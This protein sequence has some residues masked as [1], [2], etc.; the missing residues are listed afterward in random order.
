MNESRASEGK[1]TELDEFRILRRLGGAPDGATYLAHDR[2]LDRPVVLRFFPRPTEGAGDRLEAT[3]ALARVSH[4]SISAVHRVSSLGDRPYA[5]LEHANGDR[6]DTLPAP[7]SPDRVLD[8]GRALAGGIAALH[9]E[10]IAHGDVRPEQIFI[11][12][13]GTPQLVVGHARVADSPAALSRDVRALV[14]LLELYADAEL[15]GRMACVM[16]AREQTAEGLLHALDG[17]TRQSSSAEAAADN[18]Y[19]G[20]DAFGAEHAETFFGREAHVAQAI[21][22]L[23]GA[24]WLLVA[25]P[26]GGGKTSFVQ[27]GLAP[28]VARGDLGERPRWDVVSVVPGR[29]PLHAL[30]AALAPVVGET[31]EALHE[32]LSADAAVA[33]RL[34][35]ARTSTGLLLV[36]DP[37]EDV[38]D[39]PETLEKERTL[40]ALESFGALA[41]GVRL[42]LTLRAD[43]L[44]RLAGEPVGRGWLAASFMLPTMRDAELAKVVTGPARARGF[45]M[46]SPAMVDALVAEASGSP[47]SLPLLSFVLAE[48]WNKREPEAR[49]IPMAALRQLGGAAHSLARRGEVVLASLA[50]A[51]RKAARRVLVA[52]ALEAEGRSPPTRETLG[53]TDGA[54]RRALEALMGGRLVVEGETR[55]LAHGG[56]VDAWPR[57]RAW[58]DEA[59]SAR[60][61]KLRLEAAAREWVRLGGQSDGLWSARQIADLEDPGAIQGSTESAR[62]FL[63]A[64]RRVA[65]R[66][67]R[68]KWAL[69]LGL[70][71]LLAVVAGVAWVGSVRRHRAAA[72]ARVAEARELAEKASQSERAVADHRARAL[73]LFDQDEVGAAEEEWKAMIA[74]EAETERQRRGVGEVLDR[75][76]ALEPTDASARSLYADV[77]FARLLAAEQLH[78]G[79]LTAA[80]RGRLG[81][82]DDGSHAARL[83]TPA[84]VHVDTDPPGATVVLSRYRD[85]GNG[86][87][88]AVDPRSLTPSEARDLA[89]GSYLAV[90]TLDGRV[91]TRFPFTLDRGED[92]S[93]RI[94]LPRTEDVPRGLVYVPAGRFLYGS[95]DDE[96]TREFLFHQPMRPVDLPAF[97]IAR[98]E[99]TWGGY[100]AFLRDPS[101]AARLSHMPTELSMDPSGRATFE[102]GQIKL[103][104]GQTYC[105]ARRPC[106][107]WRSLPVVSVNRDDAEAYASWLA[108]SGRIPGARLCSDRE[109]ERAARGAD[110]RRF[111]W[112][113][114][115]AARGESCSVANGSDVVVPGLCEPGTHPASE[116]AFGVLDMTG[117]VW[118][119]TGSTPDAKDPGMASV[120]GGEALGSASR[121]ALSNRGILSHKTRGIGCG[122]RVCADAR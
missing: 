73:A 11:S 22:R 69:R 96:A 51:E 81:S 12:S 71:L 5:V 116:T 28:A 84:R 37:L 85:A 70:P 53:E 43:H 38:L 66:K 101:E 54:T 44:E 17:L 40:D 68:Q 64:S 83:V 92:R 67:A 72:T 117:S 82:Y 46:E 61:A 31:L 60:A 45:E 87:R 114:A 78:D 90:A 99:T 7:L 108:R 94:A 21:V 56:L 103:G 10:G 80:L 33:G 79:S 34:A 91:T 55:R 42:V 89:P 8:L 111:P 4:P 112:G 95:G 57:L 65:R 93:L 20:L 107:D 105:P 63:D 58:M 88:I 50:P 76:L 75:A 118:E 9:A 102:L 109:W 120:R 13:Q 16:A 110:D 24:P 122:I 23:G 35:R 18:P 19:R 41:P 47:E 25:A 2:M 52:L 121:L 104:E 113:D 100:L 32:G 106:V 62:A 49:V 30:A 1:L 6:L 77:I 14:A 74:S 115:E 27:A 26:P 97:L 86:H 98:T 119:W 59:S 39:S 48:L 36:V 15:R 3:I 29:R